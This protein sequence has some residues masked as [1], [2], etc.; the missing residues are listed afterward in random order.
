MKIYDCFT[1]FNELDLLE[2]R[3]KE[4]YDTVDY[5]VIA[6]SNISHSGNPKEYIL[7]NNWDRFKPWH[8]KIR[9]VQVD[10]MPNTDQSWIREKYQ[11]YSLQKGLT[12]V[13]SNDLIVVSDMDEIPRATHLQAIKDDPNMYERYILAIPMLQFRINFMKVHEFHRC[14]NII[15]TRAGVFTNAQQEREYTFS[16]GEKPKDM[17]YLEHGGWHFTYFGDDEHAVTKIK[18]FAHTETNVPRFTTDKLAI[19]YMIENRCGL[20][21]PDHLERFEVVAVDD[22]FPDCIT[23]DLERWSYMIVPTDTTVSVTD[24]YP[25]E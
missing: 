21:G 16:W 11:R 23:Q 3:L 17:V 5:F 18:N 22:Y 12:G 1:F 24:L 6:E 10:D 7:L 20:W 15:V 14:P 4:L 19:D 8:D 2:I 25:E 9:R 13:F